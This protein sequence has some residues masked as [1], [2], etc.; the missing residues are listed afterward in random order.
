MAANYG[1]EIYRWTAGEST[2]VSG[3]G[4]PVR[5]QV[6]HDSLSNDCPRAQTR[7]T[8]YAPLGLTALPGIAARSGG[9]VGD[10]CTGIRDAEK[11]IPG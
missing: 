7:E 3:N 5:F 11:F 8:C 2:A 9:N 10:C 6:M 4:R 1:G